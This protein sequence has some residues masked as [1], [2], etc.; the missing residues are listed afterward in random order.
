[1][2]RL[3][4]WTLLLPTWGLL[5]YVVNAV[6]MAMVCRLLSM[7]RRCIGRRVALICS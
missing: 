7:V 3:M 1:M 4:C 5:L 6:D 2:P